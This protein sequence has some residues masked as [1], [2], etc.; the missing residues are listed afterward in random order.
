MERMFSEKLKLALKQRG[1][2]QK[3]L[4]KR[5]HSTESAVSRWMS[6]EREPEPENLIKIAEALHVEKGEVL[7]WFVDEV[8]ALQKETLVQRLLGSFNEMDE[9]QQEDHVDALELRMKKAGKN[10]SN[11]KGPKDKE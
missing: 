7:G 4:A 6:G 2:S 9:D 8:P 11:R 5:T 10:D 1:I 3:T